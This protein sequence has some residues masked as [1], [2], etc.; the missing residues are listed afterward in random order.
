MESS[1]SGSLKVCSD[2]HVMLLSITLKKNIS[3]KKWFSIQAHKKRGLNFK[4]FCICRKY[5]G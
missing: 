3:Q 1:E 4:W 5:K 2:P